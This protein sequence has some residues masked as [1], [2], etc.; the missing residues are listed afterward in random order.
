M[1]T[2]QLSLLT[3]LLGAAVFLASM[4]P[5]S[6]FA[7][8]PIAGT[9]KLISIN[10][11]DTETKE[12]KAIFGEHPT[13]MTVFTPQG[14]IVTLWTADGRKG[15]QTEADG[16]RNFKTM[17]AIAGTY[18]IEGNKYVLKLEV[19]WNPDVVGS[20]MTRE[21][22]IDGNR[23][24]IITAPAPDPRLGPSRMSQT[25]SVWERIEQ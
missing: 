10:L 23:L 18:R 4:I 6:V 7:E 5:H 3:A 15:G 9:W 19:A 17:F 8:E 20:E 12:H 24:S 22:K 16:A 11:V 1:K 21:F 25:I 13:G 2:R 14:R